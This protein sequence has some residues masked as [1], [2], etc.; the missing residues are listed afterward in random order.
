MEDLKKYF[1]ITLLIDRPCDTR[2][3]LLELHN[4]SS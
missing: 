1:A 2:D 3:A 4:K